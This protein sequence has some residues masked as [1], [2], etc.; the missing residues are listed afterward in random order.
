MRKTKREKL[1]E[2]IS[3]TGNLKTIEIKTTF[4]FFYF[5]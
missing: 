3:Y 5:G 1:Q 4:I 2:M